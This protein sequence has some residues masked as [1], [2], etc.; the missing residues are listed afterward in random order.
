MRNNILIVVEKISSVPSL[1]F[2][3]RLRA[4]FLC[5]IALSTTMIAPVSAYVAVED[6]KKPKPTIEEI[7]KE[8]QPKL[9]DQKEMKTNYPKG[10]KP[11]VS[12]I[13]AASDARSNTGEK[14]GLLDSILHPGEKKKG[15]ILQ[16]ALDKGAVSRM[17]KGITGEKPR[18]EG[19]ETNKRMPGELLEER[20]AT[21]SVTLN[22][23]GTYTEKKYL[24]PHF[25]KKDGSWKEI[26]TILSED[27]NPDNSTGF[28]ADAWDE[29][30][31]WITPTKH[32][33]VTEN[34]WLAQFSPSD[35]EKGM[36]RIKQG[37]DQVGF[38]PVGANKVDPVVKNNENGSQS[39]FYYDLW[40]DVDVEYLV[41]SAAVKENII[42]KNKSAVNK[43]SFKLVGAS[44]EKA[45]AKEL[46]APMYRIKGL[47]D[48]FSVAPSNLILNN[49]GLVTEKGVFT[50][51]YT[52]NEITLSVDKAY[53]KNLPAD[54]FPAVID[55]GVFTSTFGTREGGNYVSFK[56]DGYICYS[57]V[58]DPYAGALNDMGTLKYWRSAFFAP[59]EPLRNP[60]NILT[61]ATL[62]LQQRTGASYWTGYTG[63]H[64]Y[65]VG[66]ATC[67][68]N[69]NCLEGGAF[70]AAGSLDNSGNINV[71]NI[72]QEM[73]TRGDFGAW[74]LL[75]GEDGTPNSFKDFDPGTATIS[76]SYVSFTYSGTPAAPNIASPVNKQV[77]VDTQPPLTVSPMTNPN[78]STPLKYEF[79]VSSGAGGYGALVHSGLT[80]GT[81]WTVPDGI[82]QDGITYY[83]QARSYDP[84]TPV[85]SS[86]G[87]SVEFRIDT[88]IGS[89]DSTQS[90]D[91]FGPVSVNLATG[92]LSTSDST[93]TMSALAGD[94]G[95]TLDYNSPLKSRNGLVGEY[96]DWMTSSDPVLTRVDNK[97]DFSW[98]T[99]SPG[100]NVPNTWYGALW[101]GYFVA[102][103][104]GDYTFGMSGSDGAT[105]W[106]VGSITSGGGSCDSLACWGGSNLHLNEGEVVPLYAEHAV[107]GTP[108][109]SNPRFYVKGPV[110]AQVVPSGWLRTGV[111]PT[112]DG[113]GLTG[114]YYGKFDGTNTFSGN[115]A[116]LM[117]RTDP[118][119]SFNWGTTTPMP[120]GPAGYL[121][122]WTGYVTVPVS[123]NY[124]FGSKADDGTKIMLGSTP[125]TVLNDWTNHGASDHWGSSYAMAANTPTKITIEYYNS[126]GTGSFEL[127][128]KGAVTE[129][130]VPAKWLSPQAKV[131]PE[132]W[133]LGQDAAGSVGYDYIKISQESA[134]LGDST[135]GTHEYKWKNGGYAPP[136]NEDGQLVRNAD[137]T[138][139]LQDVDGRTYIFNVD[140][141]LSSVTSSA[142]DRSPA[143]LQYEYQS[144]NGGP[145]RLYKIKDGV[146]NSRAA[147]LY[148][149]G[150]TNCATAPAG[151]DTTAPTG[152]LCAVATSDGRQTNLFYTSGQLARINRPGNDNTDYLY[153]IISHSTDIAGYMLT[154]TRN[155]LANDAIAA[156]VRNDDNEAQTEIAYD[157]AG[158][159]ISIT[160]PAPTPGATRAQ[161]TVEYLAG[162]KSYVDSN[163]V[164]IPG[165]A[166]ITKEHFTGVT[167][168][169]GFARE[170]RYDELYR[171]VKD[172]S[173]DGQTAT[174]EWDSAKD[175][176]YSVTESTGL[177]R[178][179]VYDD[180]DRPVSSYGPAPG[181]WF[182]TGNP[183]NQ[184]P[185]SAYASQ[186]AR[187]DVTYDAGIS[188]PAVAWYNYKKQTNNTYGSLFGAPKIHK[189]GINASSPGALTNDFTSLPISADSGM[190]GVG[191][192]ATGKLRLATGTYTFSANT[193]DGVR[194]WVN[195]QLLV[196]AWTDSTS[197]RTTTGSSF[198]VNN[199]APLRFRLDVYR[200]TGVTGNFSLTIAQQG[201]FTA[202]SNWES[203]LKPDYSL[204]T[205]T[206]TFDSNLGN[207]TVST[208]YGSNPELA[209]SQSS[210]IDSNGLNLTTTRTF[211]PQAATGSL[212]RQTSKNLPGNL[213]SNPSFTY[214]HYGASETQDNPCT[215]DVVESHKQAGK[216]KST[217]GVDPDG[218]G[219]YLPAVSH[220]VVYDDAGR[221]VASRTNTDPWSCTT[222]DE[223]GRVLTNN[224]DG[225]SIGGSWRTARTVTYYHAFNG[226]PLMRVSS[227]TGTYEQITIDLLGRTVTYKDTSSAVTHYEYTSTGQLASKH[228]DLGDEDY[229][230]DSYF[231]LSQYKFND[232]TY[233]TVYY[234]AYSRVDY[235]D[236]NDAGDL[237]LNMN[238][239]SLS[240]SN[241]MTY[242]L[243]DGSTSISDTVNRTQSGRI[244]SDTIA[245]GSS[246]LT[247][248]YAYDAV[249]RLTGATIGSNT[250]GYGYGTQNTACDS[251][252][253]NPNAGMNGNRTSQTV[254][255]VTTY[256][257]YNYADQFTRSSSTLYSYN[258]TSY[259]EHGNLMRLS[260]DDLP[261]SQTHFRYDAADKNAYTYSFDV[262]GSGKR[263][264][265]VRDAR[266]RIV[267]RELR[268]ITGFGA[269]AT[270]AGGYSYR[271]TAPGSGMYLVRDHN[272]NVL[273]KVLPLPG[274]VTL[275]LRPNEP[276]SEDQ[277]AYTLPGM[278]GHAL[279]TTNAEGNNTS[280]GMGLLGSYIY[281]PFGSPVQSS[282]PENAVLGSY[283]FG[284]SNKLLTETSFGFSPIQMGARVYI[285]AL[286]RFT[287]IDPIEGGTA[288]NYVYALDPINFNDYSGKCI[289][290]CTAS[291]QYFQPA[292]P[293]SYFQPVATSRVVYSSAQT[294]R[295]RMTATSARAEAK[296]V[297]R[298]N[299]APITTSVQPPIAP[300]SGQAFQ[301]SS[302]GRYSPQG[303]TTAAAGGCVATVGVVWVTG[304]ATAPFTAGASSAAAIAGSPAACLSGAGGGFVT[305]LIIGDNNGEY[306]DTSVQKDAWDFLDR[307][308]YR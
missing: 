214:V 216:L 63:T 8:N 157:Y 217:T 38:T 235:V 106:Q 173:F 121:V 288:N 65:Y 31:S 200:R 213:S 17:I 50:Q 279:I 222:Y 163:G 130:V 174:S 191:F 183:K 176:L 49:R 55:P 187:T 199:T 19:I 111:R 159:V 15:P 4:L 119:L 41:E 229:V 168:P 20:D 287:S 30:T 90:Y 165:Y 142:D 89:K 44:L 77:F 116:L 192:S 149:S 136:V 70:N 251:P 12:S 209:L 43:V 81:T 117:Q 271:Y 148:Y 27:K 283:G 172:T 277:K 166:G 272:S 297:I 190:Q 303:F 289:L 34:S 47:D 225:V 147:T 291:A 26:K 100:P 61:N 133:K 23:D 244:S 181:A 152:M 32:Y 95:V 40:K 120:N 42:I 160:Q 194:L 37:G 108:T 146:N 203:Y 46:Q 273:E 140:G 135:G 16:K 156:G 84:V 247:S 307:L 25:Y 260:R 137:G 18:T 278:L 234:D 230:Y 266:D 83:V 52:D 122:R 128:V 250:Y 54:A 56:S 129:Q 76:G 73:V 35:F 198:T 280:S 220:E 21:T 24:T 265:Y 72:Y 243:G 284:G 301:R 215:T 259:D 94:M 239:D 223:R 71:T 269:T 252:Y 210:T 154:G 131:L 60:G 57:N 93:H 201:G 261:E 188:G 98:G 86:W 292:A 155:S 22:T 5:T 13:P 184:V 10:K 124:I 134:V 9:E 87:S 3:T 275:T 248:S 285:P 103:K 6:A 202:T 264:D 255:G 300:Y 150:D 219:G 205:S 182:D 28:I 132:G 11:V 96:Y 33:T 127:K 241:N 197:A 286:G 125:T 195:D 115:N 238:R 58:C 232:I 79:R 249:G 69:F 281:D 123:G 171:T 231:R 162:T 245:D 263:I 298:A 36:L 64:T 237:R 126:S 118:Y 221:L 78:N 179:N 253:E 295:V 110:S 141:T 62:H 48:S 177:K 204:A 189:T 138:H 270:M 164:T 246:S 218:S 240:R 99:G 178:T 101:N 114:S 170:V 276:D 109:T 107:F 175:L 45:P 258:E 308:R 304:L 296:P 53:L 282:N 68:N 302:V 211:E 105:Y 185:L 299:V 267:T 293:V 306:M 224:V 236:Y 161:H 92:N 82:L 227:G 143:A 226:N 144:V 294:R 233:A 75:G 1:V 66:H 262:N 167:E 102:P 113:Q 153:Q 67:L 7:L 39:V 151:F 228:G 290:Q 112:S 254:N 257:C 196:D 305:Y 29:V 212:L 274:G 242:I 85:Y 268:N 169:N 2:S 91:S 208:N 139:T 193:P 80:S 104:T 97:I 206:T 74:L 158:K 14:L 180:E 186:V 207:S 145:S 88:R 256:N 59:Y 51:H